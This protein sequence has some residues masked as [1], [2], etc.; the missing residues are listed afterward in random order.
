MHATRIDMAT[1][2]N[3]ESNNSFRELIPELE[4]LVGV[5][6]NLGNSYMNFELITDLITQKLVGLGTFGDNDLHG[7]SLKD[8]GRL[9][10]DAFLK[11][12]ITIS[13]AVPPMDPE[14]K[15]DLDCLEILAE[16][17]TLA[18]KMTKYPVTSPESSSILDHVIVMEL[19]E[20]WKAFEKGVMVK[21]DVNSMKALEIAASLRDTL[22]PYF[23]MRIDKFIAQKLRIL[24]IR[25]AGKSDVQFDDV[26]GHKLIDRTLKVHQDPNKQDTGFCLGDSEAAIVNVGMGNLELNEYD[27]STIVSVHDLEQGS[28]YLPSPG[29]DWRTLDA[30]IASLLSRVTAGENE[31]KQA[32]ENSSI[33]E[34]EAGNRDLVLHIETLEEDLRKQGTLIATFKTREAGPELEFSD[35]KEEHAKIKEELR[36]MTEAY[37]DRKADA[38]GLHKDLVEQRLSSIKEVLKINE[39]MEE[40]E[41][42]IKDLEDAKTTIHRTKQWSSDRLDEDVVREEGGKKDQDDVVSCVRPHLRSMEAADKALPKRPEDDN[43]WSS[44]SVGEVTPTSSNGSVRFTNQSWDA[45]MAR[46]YGSRT[47]QAHLKTMKEGPRRS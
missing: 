1:M 28:L 44:R 31:L 11:K 29:L 35:M 17:A 2:A 36:Q 37:E 32:K 9:I 16:W 39:L 24:S 23:H 21:D 22:C 18:S 38:V 42:L 26:R 12:M 25:Q 33:Q 7:V 10:L 13:S 46:E 5:W 34:L 27:F 3:P 43:G 40:K 20:L 19:N 15:S 8:V 14:Y 4:R 6:K 41:V 45:Y 47:W 30:P